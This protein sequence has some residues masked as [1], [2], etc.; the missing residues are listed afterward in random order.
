MVVQR[1]DLAAASRVAMASALS[2]RHRYALRGGDDAHRRGLI[3]KAP[4]KIEPSSRKPCPSGA[5]SSRRL[6]VEEVSLGVRV[7]A[8]GMP[9]SDRRGMA[10]WRR[11]AG[12]VLHAICA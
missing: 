7:A 3:M 8:G 5:Q 11:D 1:L 2:G 9:G 6:N 12:I 4:W 10:C